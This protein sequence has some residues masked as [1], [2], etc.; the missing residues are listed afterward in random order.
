MPKTLQTEVQRPMVSPL[1]E[2]N[3]QESIDLETDSQPYSD[4]SSEV[5]LN[6]SKNVLFQGEGP[7][8]LT[9][10]TNRRAKRLVPECRKD[11]H[12]WQKR[13]KNNDAARKSRDLK[14]RKE[15]DIRKNLT[16]LQQHNLMLQKELQVLKKAFNLSKEKRYIGINSDG[17][18]LCTPLFSNINMVAN[19]STGPKYSALPL[20]NEETVGA[21]KDHQFRRVGQVGCLDPGHEKQ[22]TRQHCYNLSQQRNSFRKCNYALDVSSYQANHPYYV[23]RRHSPTESLDS[24]CDGTVCSELS[25]ESDQSTSSPVIY[26]LQVNNEQYS[27]PNYPQYL[28]Y[29]NTKKNVDAVQ[30][31]QQRNVVPDQLYNV[32]YWPH[33]TGQGNSERSQELLKHAHNNNCDCHGMPDV[34]QGFELQR[35]LQYQTYT[36]EKGQN[37]SSLE[38]PQLRY[39]SAFK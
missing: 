38:K 20:H 18:L 19:E 4:S 39:K 7:P 17:C 28:R 36:G 10:Y 24:Q 27:I 16:E 11:D 13:K 35:T 25:H 21:A 32:H 15:N 34:S 5:V 14:R 8:V 33:G 29:I 37:V 12:Y 6:A 23:K 3:H 22:K 30:F 26:K 9:K 1:E 31:V 2:S